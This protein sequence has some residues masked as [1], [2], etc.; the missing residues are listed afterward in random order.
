MVWRFLDEVFDV[1]A[2]DAGLDKVGLATLISI[3]EY[4]DDM[5]MVAQS[6]HCLGFPGYPGTGCFVQTFSLDESEGDVSV[7]NGIMSQEDFLLTALAKFL[8]DGVTAVSKG[9]GGVRNGGW[10]CTGGCLS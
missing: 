10:W 9:G 2:G 4:G 7:E 1:T 3:V 8:L 5:R 6:P